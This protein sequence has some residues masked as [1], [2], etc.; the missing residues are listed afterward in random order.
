M[1]DRET[2]GQL[3]ELDRRL[4]QIYGAAYTDAVS[5]RAEAIE[6]LTMFD[7]AYPPDTLTGLS[8]AQI[9]LYRNTFLRNIERE[10]QLIDGMARDISLAGATAARLI[11]D[12]SF[13]V[14]RT[15]YRWSLGDVGRQA[16]MSI[17]WQVYDRNQLWAIYRNAPRSPFSQV[18]LNKLG[19]SP[20]TARRIIE[21]RL[22]NELSQAVRYGESIAK[23]N[24]RIRHVTGMSHR[25]AQRVA[26]TEMLRV[27]NQGRMLG[28]EQARDD[29]G[30]DMLKMWVHSRKKDARP[31]HVE[32]DGV[33]AELHE[34]FTVGGEKMKYPLD[35]DASAANVINCGCGIVSVLKGFSFS[36]E[37][38]HG[39]PEVDKA[40]NIDYNKS[41]NSGK[42]SPLVSFDDYL[43][44]IR[45]FDEKL[46]GL[47][48][49]DGNK[50]KG[51]SKH[52]IERYFGS[53]S[54]RRSGVD[55]HMITEAL[56]TDKNP[57]ISQKGH[58][59]RYITSGAEVSLNPKTGNLIQTNPHDR[60][61]I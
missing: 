50:I 17:S 23:I 26:R 8:Q 41:I 6:R 2:N 54:E 28:F 1:M 12:T 59:A 36:K 58:S 25:D 44:A 5:R 34:S 20:D 61:K 33:T 42:L 11:Q 31:H 19:L 52:F 9:D 51:Y 39:Q 57:K 49:S 3:R 53:V 10:T 24:R 38:M 46:I 47:T 21:Q 40:H 37:N 18:A 55:L 29:F 35:P 27:A 32:M 45:A 43:S 16:R 22:Q 15:G 56:T 60:R 4:A 48:T 13:D 14:Y 30:I 7:R